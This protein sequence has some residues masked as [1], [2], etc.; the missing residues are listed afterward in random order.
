MLINVGVKRVVCLE[1][2]ADELGERV[3]T[4]AGVQIF[5]AP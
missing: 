5:L 2:Y 3:L 1:K 4:T